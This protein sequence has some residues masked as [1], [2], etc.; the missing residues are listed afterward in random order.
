MRNCFLIAILLVC[1]PAAFSQNNSSNNSLQQAAGRSNTYAIVVGISK[2]ESTGITQLEYAD[3][4]AKV[5]ASYL[6]SKAGGS[7]P[8][9]NIRLLTNESATFAAV[10]DAMS[11]LMETCQE[12]DMVYFYFSGHGDMENN[13]IYKLGFLLTYNTPRFNYLNNAV[14]LED[15]NNFANTLSVQKQARVVLIT[16]ACHS[17]NLAGNEFRGSMLVGDQLRTVQGNEVRITSCGPN[18][19]SNEDEGWGGGRGVFS[20]YLV[21]G[22]IGLADNMNKGIVTVKE[23]GGYLDSSLSKDILL[24]QKDQ[25]Q[26]PVINGPDNFRL[27]TVN[28]ISLDSLR[29]RFSS[30]SISQNSRATIFLKPLPVQPLGYFFN[31]IGKKNIEELVDFN[32]LDQLP[33]EDVPST[34][35]KMLV[36][37]LQ[38]EST[39]G[40]PDSLKVKVDL[41]RIDQ[42]EKS[43][44]QNPDALKRFND[45]LVVTLSDR[46]QEIINL[47]LNGDAAE[48]ERRQ[49]Y[50]VNSSGYDIY[51]KMFSVA[52]KLADPQ[53]QLYHILQVKLHYFAGV[54]ARL[55]MPTLEDPKPLLDLAMAEQEKAF[56]LEENAAY[57]QNELGILHEFKKDYAAAEKYFF[58]ATQI[59]PTWAIPWANMCG[60]YALEKKFDK[61][62][63]AGHIADSLQPGLATT[64]VNLGMVNE[65]SG[66]LLFAEEDYRKSIDINSRP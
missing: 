32:K 57:I 8:P 62:L 64:S 20:Y 59:A 50:N 36:D 48:L 30:G 51:P 26:T 23:I 60:L 2:Y 5:F 56:Q 21:N 31:L 52:L 44:Q 41:N 16:D 39:S 3:R 63:E 14:R 49:Y 27:A 25:K 7:V 65:T 55:K 13:T 22:M 66:N 43:F 4:D 9:E 54:A 17:G 28:K 61:G 24:A 45:K 40:L 12:G 33:K 29:Q 46:G 11:W 18:Q 35:I 1:C 19:L 15:L 34:F 10:Y 58:R 47:Y 37:T 6:E 53:S 42:L 38:R